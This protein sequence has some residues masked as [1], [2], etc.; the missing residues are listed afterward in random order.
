MN[1]CEEIYPGIFKVVQSRSRRIAPPVNI[2]IIPGED[3]LIFDAGYGDDTSIRLIGEAITYIQNLNKNWRISRVLPSHTH[4]DHFSGLQQ[5]KN[6]YQ[7]E[8]MLTNQMASVL[9]NKHTYRNSYRL[10]PVQK[11][12]YSTILERMSELP[13][14]IVFRTMYK[15]V[16]GI[17]FVQS[18]DIT[19]RPGETISINGYTFAIIHGPG[20]CNDHIMLYDK[21]E[22]VLFA[23]DNILRSIYTWLGP[24]R[25]NLQEYYNT[26]EACL[27][28]PNLKLVLSAHGSPILNPI[29]RIK[30]II[31]Y[32]KLRTRQVYS[33]VANETHG[34]TFYRLLNS[35]Y[36][37]SLERRWL[38]KGWIIVTLE[39]L[40]NNNIL[41]FE[42]RKIKLGNNDI[43]TV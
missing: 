10:S 36:P 25:S 39:Y 26:L 4:P 35:I 12:R 29:E 24:P 1:S 19:I 28:L 38:A 33:I 41:K 32:R 30:E 20:H 23:G 5:L 17:A 34:I 21:K 18:H 11:Y 8:V 2:Y 3:G 7:L 9:S 22:G 31:E 37:R 6:R 15:K 14:Q 13:L 40:V 27:R 16:Y 42:G 43:N